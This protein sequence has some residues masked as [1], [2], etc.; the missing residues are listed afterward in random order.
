MSRAYLDGFFN[1]HTGETVGLDNNT[2]TLRVEVAHD[3]LEA[4]VLLSNQV[5]FGDFN[6]LKG[7]VGGTGRPDTRA[8]HLAG[9]DTGHG[10]LNQYEGDAVEAWFTCAASNSEVIGIDTIQIGHCEYL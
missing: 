9:G 3:I 6:I 7:D 10:S 2:Q 4:L 5:L 1:A 8:V